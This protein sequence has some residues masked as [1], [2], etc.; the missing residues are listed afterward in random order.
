[1]EAASVAWHP[2]GWKSVGFSEIE[3]FPCAILKHRFP[4]TPNYG[5][6][7]KHAEWQIEPGTVDILV[8][9]TPCQSF[10]I[11]GKRGGMDDERG[12]LALAFAGLA[13]RQR[14]E[15]IIWENVVGVLSSNGGRDFGAFQRSLVE[16]GYS[17]AWRVLDASRFGVAQRRRRCFVVAH[18]S[19][20]WRYPAAVLFESDSLSGDLGKSRKEKKENTGDASVGAEGSGGQRVFGSYSDPEVAFTLE[21]TSHDW[22]RS[23][24]MSMIMS[25]LSFQPGNLRRQGGSDPSFEVFPTLSCDSGDQNPHVAIPPH[26][27]RRLT[28]EE[29]EKLQGFPTGWSKIPY[30]GRAEENCGDA[31]RYAA[32]GNSMAVP[33]MRWI[34]ERIQ[35]INQHAKKQ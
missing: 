21:T 33:V 2:L 23:D 31:Q 34:G 19:G 9:G 17:V 16:L 18:R 20:D 24:Q 12:K 1:M 28:P 27:V 35:F 26:T 25:P 15:W 22:S 5:D 32:I 4:N 3:P 30:K 29:C 8:G 13:E 11:A 6:L 14:P 7:T 10:S